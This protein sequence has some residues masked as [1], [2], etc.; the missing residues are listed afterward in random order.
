MNTKCC[1]PS[2]RLWAAILV[3]IVA[4]LLV[5]PAYGALI[6]LNRSP[7][8]PQCIRNDGTEAENYNYTV[9]FSTIANYYTDVIRDPSSTIVRGIFYDCTGNNA[10]LVPPGFQYVNIGSGCPSPI[11]R[12]QT[13]NPGAGAALGRYEIEISFFSIQGGS[14]FEAKAAVT[15]YVCLTKGNLVITK[16]NDLN[17]NGVRDPGEPGVANWLMTIQTP[18]GD[19]VGRL[20]DG[21]GL[22]TLNGV[23]AGSYTITESSVSGW[24]PTTPTS[25][26]TTVTNGGTAQVAFGNVR[27]ISISGGAFHDL[28]CNGVKDPSDPPL[29]GATFTLTDVAGNPVND[30]DGNPVAPQTGSTFSFTNLFPGTY[31]VVETNPVGYSSTNAIPG[32]GGTKIG[33]D[34][35]QIA[36]T[37]PNTAYSGNNYLDC[38]PAPC[39]TITKTANPTSQYIGGTVVYTFSVHNC[40]NTPLTVTNLQDDKLGNLLSDFQTANGGSLTMQAGVTVNFTKNYVIQPSDPN[41]IINTV[42]IDASDPFGTSLHQTDTETVTIIPPPPVSI[43]GGSFDDANCDGVLDPTDPPLAGATFTLTDLAGA[44]V[45][46]INGFVVAPQVGSTYNFINLNAGSYRVTETAPVGFQNRN[47]VPGTGGT[48]L[49]NNMLRVDSTTPGNAYPNNSFLNCAPAPCIDLTKVP[50]VAN[51]YDGGLIR[52][53]FTVTNCGNTPLNAH[54]LDSVLGDLTPLLVAANGGTDVIPAGGSVQFIKSHTVVPADPDPLVNNATATGTDPY[55]T[56]VTDPATA[57]VN[58]LRP[59]IDITKVAAPTAG[60]EGD[61]ITYTFT[62]S[63][64]GNRALTSVTVNDTV[65][66][67]LTA[68][69]VA[70]NSGSDTLALAATVVFTKN[71]TLAASDPDMLTNTVTVTGLDPLSKQYSHS[72]TESVDV[73]RPCIEVVKTVDPTYANMGEQ[74]VYTYTVTNCGNVDLHD[75]T[76][77]DDRLGD[78]TADFIA[79]NGGTDVLVVATSATWTEN[80]T[81]ASETPNPLVNTVTASGFDP[82]HLSVTDTDTA[83]VNIPV[84]ISGGAFYDVSGN[85]ILE[86]GDPPLPGATFTIKTLAGQN[87]QNIFGQCV[88]PQTGSTFS[89]TNLFP[90]SY[91]ITETNPP[92]YT[93]TNAIPGPSGTKITVDKIRVDAVPHLFY[94]SNW[95]L[96]TLLG[97]GSISGTK[98][99]SDTLLPIPNVTITLRES[100]GRVAGVVKTDALGNY[101]FEK[102]PA[103]IYRVTET[104]LPGYVSTD[105]TPGPYANVLDFNNIRVNLPDGEESP[106]N[107]FYDTRTGDCIS[108]DKSVSP[109]I[110]AVGNVLTYTFVVRNCGIVNLT[111][112]TVVDNVLGDLTP[113]FMAANNGS[114]TLPVGVS[115][116]FQVRYT[117]PVGAP[118]PLVNT[119]TATGNTPFGTQATDTDTA[120]VELASP[121]ISIS[122]SATPDQVGGPGDVVTYG[123]VVE[124]CGDVPISDV[125]VV[126]SV[127]G[128]LTALFI[129][130]NGGSDT[131]AVGASVA[132]STDYTLPDDAVFPFT[133]TVT[134]TGKDP[135]GGTVTGQ[136][137]ALVT[138]SE[139]CVSIAASDHPATAKIGDTI[140]CKI[141]ICNCGNKPLNDIQIGCCPCGL[142]SAAVAPPCTDL[143]PF[144]KAANNGSDGLCI[145]SCVTFDYSHTVAATDPQPLCFTLMVQGDAQGAI[146]SSSQDVAIEIDSNQ[147]GNPL[148]PVTLTQSGWD[149]N[150]E[151]FVYPK[152]RTAFAGFVYYGSPAPNQLIVGYRNTIRYTGSTASLTRLCLFLPQTGPCGSLRHSYDSPWSTTEAGILAG[153]SIAL[154]M[155]IAYNDMRLMP[156]SPGYDLESFTVNQGLLRGRTVRQVLDIANRIMGGMPPCAYGIPN[157]AVLVQILQSINGNYEWVDFNTYIDRGYLTPNRPLGPPNPPHPPVVP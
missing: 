37:T 128:D 121:C 141:T 80:Y 16:F 32:T 31:R 125:T 30:A 35:L 119:V 74:V 120:S 102:L 86:P 97:T 77:S 45:L 155:N 81:V 82:I 62:V 11:S 1:A 135:F 83:T 137:S 23:G 13:F 139:A 40:G 2:C 93:S 51:Q 34:T 63:N 129:I 108:I 27:P 106:G 88:C 103:G 8:P 75:V 96:D 151:E 70:A 111:G 148:Q 14:A 104:D 122:K 66:G 127:L 146:V 113:Q 84:T 107:I 154:M 116:T 7:E 117:I 28:T 110:A 90:G 79:A 50:D 15:F 60:R 95:F 12:T 130:A 138:L 52:Y 21:S 118:N 91:I 41:P 4:V 9:T 145:G 47:A 105:A 89:F 140:T 55:G 100:S 10:G 18:I 126:D 49:A 78:L 133:N 131:L 20:T 26:T 48:K 67:D 22:V 54:V 152:F 71:H 76:V 132:F 25:V 99:D 101:S 33:N 134:V 46:D 43:T 147:K 123:F 58:I 59:C 142:G 19:T 144:F 56:I 94:P 61:V 109:T 42:T 115:V 73:L 98:F 36:A 38:P 64:C 85:G 114:D 24:K 5:S 143:T 68:D 17:A 39:L 136:D 29:A 124:N 92:L 87:V 149:L 69:F 3:S 44:P 150:C 157:C 6:S 65:Y 156:R 72:D 53:T 153:E 112:V 57:S